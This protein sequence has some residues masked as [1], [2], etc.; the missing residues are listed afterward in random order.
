MFLQVKTMTYYNELRKELFEHHF[1]FASSP[2]K[3]YI[4]SGDSVCF[5]QK[6]KEESPLAQGGVKTATLEAIAL[7]EK[8]AAERRAANALLIKRDQ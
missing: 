7:R 4:A 1:S 5:C 8:E 6:A 2:E 3:H